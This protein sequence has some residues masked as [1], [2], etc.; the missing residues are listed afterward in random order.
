MLRLGRKIFL[1]TL[2]I[3]PV[4]FET[5]GI[6]SMKA[7]L[8][9]L[10]AVLAACSPPLTR[11]SAWPCPSSGLDPSA[12]LAVADQPKPIEL[13]VPPTPIPTNVAGHRSTIR[14]VVDTLGRVM[15]DSITVCGLPN[16]SYAKR[17]AEAAAAVRFRPRVVANRAVIAPALLVYDF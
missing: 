11:V 13:F 16:A 17:L 3:Q 14:V 12:L 2:A 4:E 7:A 1:E 6:R 5:T 8:P 10:F 15:S 9:V